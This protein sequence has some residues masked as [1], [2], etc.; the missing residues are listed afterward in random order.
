[1]IE[2]IRKLT[3]VFSPSG[4]E[5]AIR[6]V[7]RDEIK[8]L[9]DEVRMDALGNLIARKGRRG[10]QG[11]R[12][13]VAAHMDEIGLMVTHV[14]DRGF[15]RF[16][17]LGGVAPRNLAGS[18]V[19]FINGVEGVV[20]LE[21]GIS[22]N[23]VPPLDK[24]FIDVGATGKRD[25]TVRTGDVAGFER[26]FLK[27]GDRLV[28]KSMDDRI[29]CAVAI[30]VL[31]NLR[32]SPHEIYFVFTAQEEVGTR[33]AQTSSYENDPDLGFSIDVTGWGDT[34][35]V[36]GVEM[37]LGQGPA[38]K[39]RDSGMLADPRIVQW[40]IRTAE[41]AGIPYQR[42]VLLGRT[43]DARAMQL[44]RSGVQVGCLSIPCRY[45]HSPSEMVDV[46]DVLNAVKL[47]GALLRSPV[48]LL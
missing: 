5:E 7:I 41:K 11:R 35:G 3:G 29:G 6:K 19:R 28:A 40:M 37:A 25:C 4:S 45:V 36:R 10:S 21:P 12:I 32:N 16:S 18:R 42:E 22:A 9:V 26:P 1:M 14:D 15:V 48:N 33:G 38:I 8:G 47:A 20:W 34:P 43:T 44:S 2:L 30:Q 27:L 13:M 39:I 23:E 31:Q 46:N 24:M 17:A